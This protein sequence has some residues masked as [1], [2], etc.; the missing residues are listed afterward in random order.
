MKS[1]TLLGSNKTTYNLYWIQFTK[2]LAEPEGWRLKRKNWSCLFMSFCKSCF[3]QCL[4]EINVRRINWSWCFNIYLAMCTSKTLHKDRTFGESLNKTQVL[5]SCLDS[6]LK[7]CRITGGKSPKLWHLS[8]SDFR[9]AYITLVVW[10]LYSRD[11]II[12]GMSH[13]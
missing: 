9:P 12:L 6:L 5:L 10:Y 1:R 3:V 11:V 8:S 4:F 13:P 7:R 2:S